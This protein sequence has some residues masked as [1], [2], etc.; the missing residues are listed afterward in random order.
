[1]FAKKLNADLFKGPEEYKNFL[2]AM[3]DALKEAQGNLVPVTV[4]DQVIAYLAPAGHALPEKTNQ[5]K[6]TIPSEEEIYAAAPNEKDLE[7]LKKVLDEFVIRHGGRGGPDAY[8]V[9]RAW[10]YADSPKFGKPP[11]ELVKEGKVDLLLEDLTRYE[12]MGG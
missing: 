8:K 6:L 9:A 2:Q 5:L 11:I 12:Q 7:T 10:L 1:M 4:N 3:E